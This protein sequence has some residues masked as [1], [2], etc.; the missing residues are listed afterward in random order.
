MKLVEGQNLGV[1]VADGHI[2]KCS[3]SDESTATLKDVMHIPGL[4]HRLF[5][6][7]KFAHHGHVVV[8][9]DNSITLYSE[10]HAAAVMLTCLSGGNN[11]AANIKVHQQKH[12]CEEHHA[13]PSTGQQDHTNNKKRLSL[14]LLHNRLEHR[15]CCTL[16]AASEHNLWEDVTVCMSFDG[17]Q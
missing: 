1:E 8:I 10:P 11:L 9:K 12:Q 16:L 15:K 3:T 17:M 7:T 5:S 14:E 4:S 2:I 13:V 6:I